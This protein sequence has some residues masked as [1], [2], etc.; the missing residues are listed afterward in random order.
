MRDE[1][2][3]LSIIS[4]GVHVRVKVV[5]LKVVGVHDGC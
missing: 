4:G 1:L 2:C 5:G 3:L